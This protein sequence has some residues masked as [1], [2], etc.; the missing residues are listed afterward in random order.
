M[1]K[2]K[3]GF[4]SLTPAQRKAVAKSGGI[5]AHRKGNAHRWTKE[6]ARLAG[7]IGGLAHSKFA[8]D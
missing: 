8:K 3:K 5:A 2:S 1:P 6:E 4:A 7:M